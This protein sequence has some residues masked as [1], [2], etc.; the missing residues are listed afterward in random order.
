MRNFLSATTYASWTRHTSS[1][2]YRCDFLLTYFGEKDEVRIIIEYDGFSEHFV[3][4]EKVSSH[5]W[6][7]FYR[8]EDIEREFTIESYGYKFLG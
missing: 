3:N 1:P 5:N 2:A 7:Q 6:E 4:R 8:P